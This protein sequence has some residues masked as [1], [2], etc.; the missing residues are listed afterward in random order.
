MVNSGE[1]SVLIHFMNVTTTYVFLVSKVV[2]LLNRIGG[3]ACYQGNSDP[4]FL[5]FPNIH[6]DAMMDHSSKSTLF[7][8]SCCYTPV[9]RRKQS[10]CC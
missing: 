7:M 5:N 10:C 9:Y 8:Y 6:K 3:S 1:K 4:E 2:E